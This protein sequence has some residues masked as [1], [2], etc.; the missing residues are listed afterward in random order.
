MLDS[1]STYLSYYSAETVYL[2]IQLTGGK[3]LGDLARLKYLTDSVLVRYRVES[4]DTELHYCYRQTTDRR[5][6]RSTEY[7]AH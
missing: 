2:V 4:T 5:I 6:S 3:R 1:F 7:T